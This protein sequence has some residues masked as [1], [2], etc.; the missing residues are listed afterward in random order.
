MD[1]FVTVFLELQASIRRRPSAKK[2]DRLMP[3]VVEID[4]IPNRRNSPLNSRA[5]FSDGSGIRF[6]RMREKNLR[7]KISALSSL[8]TIEWE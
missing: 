1:S 4:K 3:I 6:F 2:I 7:R 8:Q 5:R